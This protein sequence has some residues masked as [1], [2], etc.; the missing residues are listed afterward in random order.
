MNIRREDRVL[1]IAGKERGKTGLVRQVIP[2]ESRVIVEGLNIVKRHMRPRSTTARQA[3]I[4]EKEAPLHIS[5][6]Q[7]LCPSCEKPTR[8]GHRF[9]EDGTKV[10]YCKRCNELIVDKLANK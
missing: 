5:N 9:L 4:I 3:G 6:L 10:R 7:L 1:V 8:T 2:S